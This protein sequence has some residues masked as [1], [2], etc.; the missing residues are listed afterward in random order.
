MVEQALP[1]G[2]SRDRQRRCDS[3]VDVHRQRCE[4]T[5]F[6]SG[7]LRERAVASP[8]GEPEHPLTDA[9]KCGAVTQLNHD[10]RQLVAG[11]ARCPVTTRAVDPG[12]R[13]VKLPGCET[14]G[15]YPHD[16]VV[17]GRLGVGQVRQ[18]Q[19]SDTGVTI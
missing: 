13:P 12:V 7:V 1:G 5:G 9:Q 17:V 2:Q 3:M 6:H 18:R 11:H 10:A 4:I 8:V 19:A 16:D 14:R 15:V